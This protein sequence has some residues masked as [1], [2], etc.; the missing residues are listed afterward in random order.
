MQRFEKKLDNHRKELEVKN[1]QIATLE[2]RLDE[3]EKKF[4]DEKKNKEKKIKE[5]EILLKSKSSGEKI[6]E[7]EQKAFKCKECDFETVSQ[8]GLLIHI[9][10]KHT[11]FRY[12]NYL[13]ECDF[14][15]Q[16]LNSE[17]EMKMHLKTCHTVKDAPFRCEDGD[18]VGE[19]EPTVSLHH[20]KCHSSDFECGVCDFK[21]KNLKK[22]NT[23]LST[24]ESYE[25]DE[26]YFRVKTLGAIKSHMK[27]L[28]EQDDV[29][30]NHLK[31][32]RKDENFVNIT[33]HWRHEL[34]ESE[35]N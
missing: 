3:L 19:N 7:K 4:V 34:F 13:S 23:H 16:T 8:R 29:K 12:E 15:E 33:E 9:K 30:I 21:A 31:L 35:T 28:H 6:E 5:L 18:F 14:G 2:I 27:E 25:C 20:G 32:D 17:R 26:C 11:N 10:R 24:C 22:L 1:S